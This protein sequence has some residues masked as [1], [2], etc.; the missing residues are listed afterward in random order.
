[1]NPV[2]P[3]TRKCPSCKNDV[4]LYTGD[5]HRFYGCVHCGSYFRNEGGNWVKTLKQQLPLEKA[6]SIGMHVKLDDIDYVVISQT[7]RAVTDSIYSWTEFL[8]YHPQHPIASLSLN[9]GHWHLFTPRPLPVVA[10]SNTAA[11]RGRVYKLFS[12]DNVHT[13]QAAGEFPVA[14]H[15]KSHYTEYIDP[16]NILSREKYGDTVETYFGRYVEPEELKAACPAIGKLPWRRGVGTAQKFKTSISSRNMLVAAVLYVMALII[17]A[18]IGASRKELKTT[19][20]YD[21]RTYQA[22]GTTAPV[23]EDSLNPKYKVSNV[24]EIS[25]NHSALLFEFHCPVENSWVSTESILINL[26]TGEEIT[27]WKDVE[28]YYGY[29]DGKWTEGSNSASKIVPNLSAGTYKVLARAEGPKGSLSGMVT[30]KIFTDPPVLSNFIIFLIIGLLFPAL[31]WYRKSSFET[32][33][34]NNSD[35][36]P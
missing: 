20:T 29:D 11:Y 23:I 10:G 28:Y 25:K 36:D 21:V 12:K 13:V 16:P 7:E 32:K 9:A 22:P 34:W 35:Y 26:D 6:L 31:Y 15:L 2:Q 4:K 14:I 5:K 8:L 27:L 1:M 19:M 3:H 33:R 24:F 30:S 18:G 17:L